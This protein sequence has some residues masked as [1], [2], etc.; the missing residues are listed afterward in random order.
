M[1]TELNLEL[2]DFFLTWLNSDRDL[3]A[4][5]YEELRAHLISYLNRRQCVESEKL[6]DDALTIF[7][8]RLPHLLNKIN[9][10]LPYLLVVT[11][12]LY[13]DYI[14]TRHLSL[15][16]NIADL[17]LV[18]DEV[19]EEEQVFEY[20]DECLQQLSDEERELFLDYFRWEKQEKIDFRKELSERLGISRNALRLRIYQIKAQLRLCI[21]NRL[22]HGRR[23]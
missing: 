19:E 20:L 1:S 22:A 6:A 10:P 2:F 21:N 7:M 12:N 14:T 17:P 11:R 8:R 9:D 5:K 3:A 23:K 13:I 15:P 4:K 18:E 16:E